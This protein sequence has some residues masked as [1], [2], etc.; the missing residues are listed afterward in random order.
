MQGLRWQK[1]HDVLHDKGDIFRFKTRGVHEF[2]QTACFML[3]HEA[4]K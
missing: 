2:G 1:I 4:H 3:I